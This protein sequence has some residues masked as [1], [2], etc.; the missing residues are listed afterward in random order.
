MDKPLQLLFNQIYDNIIKEEILDGEICNICHSKIL[1]DEIKLL[2]SHY[3]HKKCLKLSTGNCVYCNKEYDITIKFFH[4][5][6]NIIIKTG[7]NKGKICGRKKCGYH[8]K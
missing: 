2:C 5:N 8:K 4:N 3:Y 6:C 7:P 1:D